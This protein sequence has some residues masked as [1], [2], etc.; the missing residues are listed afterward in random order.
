LPYATG[1]DLDFLGAIFLG[2]RLGVQ[3]A[4]SSLA[5]DNFQFYVRNGTFG[6][7]K[8]G[9]DF[10]IP[11][12]TRIST[13]NGTTGPVMITTADT[14]CPAAASSA[15]CSVVSLTSG[16]SGNGA[17]GVFLQHN[18][19]AYASSA[20]GSLLVTNNFGVVV[21]TDAET[22]TDY[23]YRINLKLQSPAGNAEANV[24]LAI[25]SV[26]GVQDVV[27]DYQAGTYTAYVYGISPQVAP[28]L[29]SMVQAAMDD[30]MTRCLPPV[31]ATIFARAGASRRL[32]KAWLRQ[33]ELELERKRFV[34]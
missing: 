20:F 10:T 22:D 9:Q 28:S 17:A 30:G 18:F 16:A 33:L 31:G 34:A 7:I 8:N 13:I 21:G 5:D 4:S 6:N 15:S 24:R 26:P 11:A 3:D 19:T 12:G 2:P 27:F 29:L 1:S 25:L 32:A 23:R 14:L